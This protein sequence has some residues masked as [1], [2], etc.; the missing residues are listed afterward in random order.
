LFIC[1]YLA[2]APSVGYMTLGALYERDGS[3]A[4]QEALAK[5]GGDVLSALGIPGA[6]QNGLFE[7]IRKQHSAVASLTDGV[8]RPHFL[9]PPPANGRPPTVELPEIMWRA[10]LAAACQLW[11]KAN[12]DTGKDRNVLA[13]EVATKFSSTM[14]GKTVREYRRRAVSGDDPR[15]AARYDE[16]LRLADEHYPGEPARAAVALIE[17]AKKQKKEAGRP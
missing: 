16:M 4:Q 9:R 3:R 12:R 14:Q 1:H 15:M 8:Q 13:S 11:L 5:L 7:P 17:S 6:A 2:A 10:D